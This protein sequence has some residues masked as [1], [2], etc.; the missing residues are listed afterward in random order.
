METFPG[1]GSDNGSEAGS[2]I[3]GVT[4][5]DVVVDVIVWVVVVGRHESN[6]AG[7]V[8]SA[9]RYFRQRLSGFLQLPSVPNEHPSQTSEI[10]VVMLE[11]AVVLVGIPPRHATE[12]NGQVRSAAS[13][14]PTQ[15]RVANSSV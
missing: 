3:S 7:H 1:P 14:Y 9:S 11:V 8:P 6:P 4:V 10:V 5:E 13:S 12:P 2:V 15:R